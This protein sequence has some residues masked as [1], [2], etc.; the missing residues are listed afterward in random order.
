MYS[1]INYYEAINSSLPTDLGEKLKALNG[2]EFVLSDLVRF[3]VGGECSSSSSS[4]L[5]AQWNSK[6]AAAK[7]ILDKLTQSSSD[8]KRAR[9]DRDAADSQSS[10]R[11][12]L[13][14]FTAI[15]SRTNDDGNPIFT[16]HSVSVT[17]PIRKKVDITIHNSTIKFT[18]PSTQAVEATVPLSSLR[19]AFLLPTRGKSKAHWTVVLLSTDIPDRGKATSTSA[20]ENPQVIFGIDA[21]TAAPFTISTYDT[22]S[23]ASANVLPKGTA[24]LPSIRDFLTH[25]GIPLHEPTIEVF[26]S[27]CAGVGNNASNGGIPGIEAHRAAKAGSLWF[28]REGIL[29]GESKPCEFWAVEDLI[30]KSEGVR[31]V[32]ASGRTCSVILTR[33]TGGDEPVGEDE[34]DMGEEMEFGMVDAREKEGI[35]Q[36]V[37]QHR[38]LFGKKKEAEV[39]KETGVAPVTIHQLDDDSDESDEDFEID[40]DED[41]S[42]SGSDSSSDEGGN[43]DAE[44]VNSDVAG[45]GEEDDDGEEDDEEETE[46]REENHPLLRAGAMPRMSRAAIEMAVGLVEQDMMGDGVESEGD[47]LEDELDE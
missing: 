26:K 2:A 11:P 25:L 18:S 32:G 30:G 6:Q 24:I 4:E 22:D 1:E 43:G 12:R 8:N 23:K 33:K 28:T 36:W 16:L 10:K 19:R 13:S 27:V 15:P 21:T 17:S 39:L 35:N 14:P 29:W 20:Q 42:G 47:E 41:D 45:S 3:V 44:T 38:H 9:D 34:E 37:R 46:L 40:S 31:I 5:K 7:A